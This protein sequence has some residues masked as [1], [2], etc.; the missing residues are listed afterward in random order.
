MA[1]KKGLGKGLDSLIPS[2][3]LDGDPV[4][5]RKDNSQSGQED[6]KETMVRISKVE[7]NRDQPRKQFDEDSLDELADSIRQFGVIQPLLVQKKGDHY[8][9]IAGERRWRA[10]KIA[11]LKEIPILVREYT[12]QEIMEIGLIENIQREN[13]NPIEEAQAYQRLIE[14]F[15]VKHEDIA[16][17][18]SKSRSFIT[19]SMR[20]L[21]LD[22]KVQQ[23]VIEGLLSGGHA[24]ALL[25]LDPEK[26]VLCAQKIVDE[27]LSVRSTEKLVKDLQKEKPEKQ[28]KE[29]R[30][31]I[32]YDELAKSLSARISTKVK[33]K[34]NGNNKGKIEIEYYSL[35]EL[36]RIQ[37]ILE[38][39]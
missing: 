38:K 16:D 26:Q 29:N 7:P 18:V 5:T 14:E 19:N 28:P 25:S 22:P 34:D 36:E 13:L 8:E 27:D 10:A 21:K 31:Q 35:E 1:A 37:K 32:F 23:M 15:H 17:R 2:G 6:G 11:G 33:I 20:L 30:N 24:R 4:Q 3:V 9:I 12:D 39:D